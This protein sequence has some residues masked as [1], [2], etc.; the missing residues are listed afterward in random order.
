MAYQFVHLES[1]SRKGDDKGRSS[2]FVFRE[3]RRDPVASVHVLNPL[4]SVLVFGMGVDA[5]EAL[6]DA[7][8]AA[9]KVDVKDGKPR[10]I[11]TDQKTL[12]TVIASHPY[13]MEE[14]RTDPAKLQ[15]AEEWER[16]T[17]A[18]LR[19]QYQDDLK[20]VVRHE[21]E[22]YFHIHAYI[23]PLNDPEMRA[24]R[25]HPGVVAKRAM[26]AAGPVEGEDNKALSKRA[27]LAYK[28]AMRAWQDSYHEAVGIPCGL[29][30]LGPQRR[31]LTRE[32]WQVEKVQA[33]ALRSTVERAKNVKARGES[34]IAAKKEDAA[35]IEAEACAAKV[36]AARLL[37]AARTATVAALAVQDK[38]TNEQRKAAAMMSRV[39][40]E[41]ARVRVAKAQLQRLPSLLCSM[42]DGFRAS[43]VQERIRAAFSDEMSKLRT[44]ASDALERARMAERARRV[45]ED[46]AETLRRS[47]ADVGRQRDSAW[48]ELAVLR[49][50]DNSSL[51]P[52]RGARS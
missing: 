29:T 19:S 10:K 35:R 6:H 23:V 27:D 45:A 4:P 41:T 52:E 7:A 21:D 20:S 31:R 11:R 48:K 8:A 2:G 3:V 17:I 1:Y 43:A 49:P 25:H 36:E 9:A 16:R 33:T 50:T 37:G 38:A 26:M 39:R 44:M 24:L 22:S 32:Q 34:F 14:V 30:R 5:V 51:K 13:T 46:K 15:E 12:H 47:L 40:Q 28:H 18:W 42:W